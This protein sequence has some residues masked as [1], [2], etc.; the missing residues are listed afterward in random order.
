[1]EDTAYERLCDNDNAA[2]LKLYE[3]AIRVHN[4][5]KSSIQFLD[6]VKAIQ[7]TRANEYEQDGGE[8]SFAKIA[9][10]FNTYT[11]KDLLP[12]DIALILEILKNVRFYSQDG[13]HA[14]SVVDKVS[15]ASLWAE[16]VTEERT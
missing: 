3:D 8:R 9:T 4:T 14:D 5:P 10:V 6:E 12:S 15:Y 2:Y 11:G 7:S 1:M 16:L 13:Y